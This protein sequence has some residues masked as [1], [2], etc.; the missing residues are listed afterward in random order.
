MRQST[1][2]VKDALEY[3]D[4]VK[5]Q[6]SESPD[7]YNRFLD[8]MKDFKSQ[9]ID[10]PGVIDRVSELFRGHP[11]LI[12]GFNTFLP[13]G[14]RID[15]S[16]DHLDNSFITVTTP[17]GTTT[18]QTNGSDHA[19]L[20]VMPPEALGPVVGS[21]VL[22]ASAPA[23]PHLPPPSAP[24]VHEG[25]SPL[26]EHPISM[27]AGL[28]V[29][30][31]ELASEHRY[32]PPPMRGPYP[33]PPPPQ[34][35]MAPGVHSVPDPSRDA[36]PDQ[37]PP[38]EFNHAINYVNKI[39]QRF[40]HDPETYKK[41][42]EILQTY[43]R[44]SRAIQEVYSEVTLLFDQDADLLEEFKQFLPDTGAQP[45]GLFGA[46]SGGA[47]DH[48]PSVVVEA[49]KT[50][51]RAPSASSFPPPATGTSTKRAKH[52]H[53][54]AEGES[55]PQVDTQ[56]VPAGPVPVPSVPSPEV[57][58]TMEV[59][60]ETDFFQRLKEH[61]GDAD[62]YYDFLKL[63][64]LF[65]EDTIDLRMLVDRAALFLGDNGDLMTIFKALTGY[66]DLKPSFWDAPEPVIENVPAAEAA[67][68][69]LLVTDSLSGQVEAATDRVL[70]TAGGDEAA[71]E[72]LR[73]VEAEREN[74]IEAEE[75]VH[76]NGENSSY[77]RLPSREV[78]A[79]CSGRDETC[80]EVLNDEWVAHPVRA[81]RGEQLPPRNKTVYERAIT[82]TEEER[83][84]F[85]YYIEATL[86]TIAL[87]EPLA[88]SNLHMTPAQRESWRLRPGLGGN[89]KT[90]YQS[91]LKKVYGPE[92]GPVLIDALHESP[93]L[94]IPLVLHR[95]RQKD[96]EWKRAQREWNKVWREVDA[97]AAP[98]ARD[99][100]LTS[101]RAAERKSLS[102]R[103]LIEDLAKRKTRQAHERMWLDPTL[104]R[105][106]GDV[107]LVATVDDVAVLADTVKLTLVYIDRAADLSARQSEQI[108]HFLRTF[109]PHLLLIST[110]EW[111]EVMET[112]GLD[113]ES[114]T[115]TSAD[116]EE[117]PV[118][119]RGRK[120]GSQA[121]LRKAL[122]KKTHVDQL[123]VELAGAAPEEAADAAAAA[124]SP[125]SDTPAH[126]EV[127]DEEPQEDESNRYHVDTSAA[128]D[129]M[130][131]GAQ[132]CF[133]DT[134]IYYV[135]RLVQVR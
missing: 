9:A 49:T 118:V 124:E 83:H 103:A 17:T 117:R 5:I 81:S 131:P 24:R 111:D 51:R 12:Q 94:T 47:P 33:P 39:K 105:P 52:K 98:R 66:A 15:C 44:E 97:R 38:V 129:P 68:P 42:L 87:L 3:L 67:R 30:P 72:S 8:I 55:V 93:G 135:V 35:M 29:T 16:V 116:E 40:S 82:S 132:L 41:F 113:E 102:S 77:R 1:L 32:A 110:D 58:P 46:L 20:P 21:S 127:V 89:S 7:V 119:R 123:Q 80:W 43:Q 26:V 18:R 85:D 23:P 14:Y 86:R 101:F 11:G 34:G 120:G 61:L 121:D 100:Q 76:Q 130:R 37:R 48:P 112:P 2:N 69:D 13:P 92:L 88:Q 71:I 56:L 107:Q 134:N 62:T 78:N 36:A 57:A 115:E 60:S 27:R 99:V 25:P 70:S 91:V 73:H 133:A 84:E 4:Q 59:L 74:I 122:L 75:G 104:P 109:L 106:R 125:V 79:A 53:K 64:T 45:A 19:P 108:E 31:S 50:K 22:H 126:E 6:F 96:D 63:L 54:P 95:L 114:Q 90:V 28:P 128:E 10:T 65:A